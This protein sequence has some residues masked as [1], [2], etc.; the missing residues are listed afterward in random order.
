MAFKLGD[1]RVNPL[2]SKGFL[3]QSPFKANGNTMAY[4]NGEPKT[5]EEAQ[6]KLDKKVDAGVDNQNWSVVDESSSI[7]QN[8]DGTT[9]TDTTT[10]WKKHFEAEGSYADLWNQNKDGVKDKYGSLEE[11]EKAGE[12]WKEKNLYKT[13]TDSN[14]TGK[15]PEPKVNPRNVLKKADVKDKTI[16]TKLTTQEVDKGDQTQGGMQP[17]EEVYYETGYDPVTGKRGKIKKTRTVYKKVG[18]TKAT[19]EQQNRE[20]VATT[21]DDKAN[22]ELDQNVVISSQGDEDQVDQAVEEQLEAQKKQGKTVDKS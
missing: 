19:T 16:G 22:A 2:K 15:K 17:V 12:L 1:K 9:T 18:N 14:T 8:E 20:A 11:F 6:Q 7:T 10:N 13:T 5:E 3:N 4:N 21:K